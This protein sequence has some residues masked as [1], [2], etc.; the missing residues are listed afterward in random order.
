MMFSFIRIDSVPFNA[1]LFV[2][3][4]LSSNPAKYLNS[5]SFVGYLIVCFMKRELGDRGNDQLD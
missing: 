2:T 5:L 1:L 3:N 4:L